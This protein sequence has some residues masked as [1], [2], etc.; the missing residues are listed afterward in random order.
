MLVK[1]AFIT[2]MPHHTT[3]E[4]TRLRRIRVR[5]AALSTSTAGS[6]TT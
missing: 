6:D 1:A 4:C 5:K 3:N 2:V